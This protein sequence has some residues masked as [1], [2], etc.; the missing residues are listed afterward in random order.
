MTIFKK[1]LL[2]LSITVMFSAI[3]A[4]TYVNDSSLIETPSGLKYK[5]TKQG[6]GNYPKSGDRVWVHYYAKFTNDSIFAST[7]ETGPL[8]VYL[9]MGQIIKGWEEGLRLIKPGG[10]IVLVVPPELGYSDKPYK[11]IPANS[12]IIYEIALLQVDSVD[13]VKPYD[14]AGKTLHKAK[15]GLK[16]YI[17]NEGTGSFAKAGDNAYVHFTGYLPDGKIFDSSV[18]RGKPARIT[19]G[20]NQVVKGWDTGLT[21]MKKGSK[22]RLII[23]AKLAYGRKG[24]KNIVPPNTPITLDLEMIDIV[25]PPEVKMW[26][27]TGKQIHTTESGLKYIIFNK[28]EGDLIKDEDIVTVH[29]SGYFTDGK[30]F[31]SSVKRFEPIQFPVGAGFVIDG[32]DEGIKLMR[33][34]A[35]FQFIIPSELAYGKE[36]NPPTVKPDTDLIF[37]IEIIDVIK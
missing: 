23:P 11:N 32:W 25:P 28:G 6:H 24:Y 22:I 21:F 1:I 20:A 18:K 17:I 8:D 27:S 13:K 7:A 9:G 5:I 12:T 14:I 31:D 29:Y 4:Q 26:D 30:L 37:D 33:K 15:K 36:G 19:V 2:T 10:A 16:Y 35:K 34:G 3:S